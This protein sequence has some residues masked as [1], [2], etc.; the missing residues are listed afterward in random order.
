MPTINPYALQF[1]QEPQ[2]LIPRESQLSEVVAN[3][4][5]DNGLQH[6]Y[7]ITGIRGSGQRI[8]LRYPEPAAETCSN[9]QSKCRKCR[10][11]GSV[12]TV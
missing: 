10:A 8:Y 12:Y 3:F 6:I 4:L 7:M 2:Q 9:P 5:S 11:S 1:G